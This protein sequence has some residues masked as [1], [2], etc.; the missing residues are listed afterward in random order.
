MLWYC[1]KGKKERK[2][3]RKIGLITLLKSLSQFCFL[4]SCGGR[5]LQEKKEK[6]NEIDLS[7][8]FFSCVYFFVV[9]KKNFLCE[10]LLFL[11]VKKRFVSRF[12]GRKIGRMFMKTKPQSPN[13]SFVFCFADMKTVTKM[14]LFVCQMNFCFVG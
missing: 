5:K 3:K 12:N 9:K 4:F 13:P 1:H 6:D 2:E 7:L 8:S 11:C 10:Q 14:Y